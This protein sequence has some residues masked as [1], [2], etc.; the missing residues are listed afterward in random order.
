VG[1]LV[2]ARAIDAAG[3]GPRRRAG[4]PGMKPLRARI[5][6]APPPRAGRARGLTQCPSAVTGRY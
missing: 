4:A 5:R 1:R 6:A 3:G 2:L